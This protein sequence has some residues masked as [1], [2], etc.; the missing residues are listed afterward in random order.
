MDRQHVDIARGQTAK[1]LSPVGVW[2]LSFGC[3]VGWGAFV[4]PGTTFLPIAGPLG[5]ALGIVA[6]A[7]VMLLIGMNY[8]FLMNRYPDAGGTMTY[9]ARTFGYDHGFLSAWFL[10]L[11]YVAIIWANASALALI[12]RYLLG[13]VFQ[14][15]FHYQLLGYDVYLG[16]ALLSMAAILLCGCVC[17]F[18]GRHAVRVQVLFAFVLLFGVLICSAVVLTSPREALRAPTALFSDGRHPIRQVLNIV[19][20]SP[21]AFVGFESVSQSTASFRFPLKRS[22]LVMGCA[23]FTGALCY[24]L[25]TLLAVSRLPEG[26]SG[27]QAYLSALSQLKGL[28]G[29][30]TF[31]AVNAVLGGRG[32]ALLGC[33]AVA[34]IVTGLIG[35]YIAAS[36]LLFSMAED[37][38]LPGWFAAEGGTGAPKNALLFLMALS[39]FIPFLGRTAIGWIVDVN[40]IGAAIAY[41][42]T[43][44]AAWFTAR[45]EHNRPVEASGIAG[46]VMS[47]V[48][49]LYFMAWNA[50][51]MATES[52]LILASWSILG[53]LF[54]HYVFRHD[55]ERRFGKSTI[56]WIALLFLIFFT[57]LV[58]VRQATEDMTKALAQNIE[59]YH[60]QH[61]DISAE[62]AQA[63]IES[64]LAYTRRLQTRNGVIQMGLITA[65]LA[66]MFSVYS[67][68]ARRE[69]QSQTDRI[70]AEELNRAKTVFLSNISHD[71][72]TPMN[73][74]VGYTSLARRK[75][76][77]PGLVEGYL[78]RIEGSSRHLLSLL[79]NVLE[80]SHIESG[81]MV[82]ESVPTDL[83]ALLDEESEQYAPRMRD[84][85]IDFSVDSFH[86]R[87]QFVV[88]DRVRLGRVLS[89]LLSNACKFTP[90][91]GEVSVSVWERPCEESGKGCYEFR[92]KDN[93][94]GM[95]PEFAAKV[96]DSF[97]RERDDASGAEGTGLGMAITR[98]IV[99]L[100]EGTI[101]VVTAPD[102]G[103]EFIVRLTFPLQS[104]D[105]DAEAVSGAS[106]TPL[107]DFHGVRLLLAEDNELSRE[108]CVL[109]LEDAGFSVD[110]AV[111]GQEAV[112]MVS[113]SAPGYYDAILT[114]IQMPVMDGYEAAKAI[115]ALSREDL[116]H[117]PILAITANTFTDD[118]RAAGIDG[119]L[120]KPI[121][122]PQ[123]LSLFAG[124]LHR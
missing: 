5:T 39:L 98:G 17:L 68:M 108:M 119:V 103:S 50:D 42:Y 78:D 2:A 99:D 84:K 83:R 34:A 53:F 30:P 44:A 91:G 88:C 101:H 106:D 113:R 8:H 32:L 81:Q 70:R 102:E 92:V 56:V 63:Y 65:S 96:F 115:R 60:E 74:I 122:M 114:D 19:A 75:L 20:L 33:A 55:R 76:G 58:W 22:L 59:M 18:G 36:R 69:R 47:A 87:N 43:S 94:P 29:L 7:A 15:G 31:H 13:G 14:F 26:F 35:N 24:L 82:L 107:P 51:A 25:L 111:N 100:M 11:V 48:F 86:L 72:R 45:Q 95:T 110:A 85:N 21:W 23:L 116:A 49:F 27:W 112:E 109:L 79:S 37:D 52:Y 120:T 93:G 16:E 41:A 4:M 117:I 89:N 118:V 9:A 66:T 57:S 3:A 123:L 12:G 67:I 64:E 61:P 46:M 104:A 77:E 80:M 28:Q 10:I 105:E 90:P 54:F 38:I 1:Y 62:D 40:T 121:D 6:G 124:L 97:E 73:A 71:I